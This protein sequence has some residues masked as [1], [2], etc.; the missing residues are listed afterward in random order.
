[1]TIKERILLTRQE[2]SIMKENLEERQCGWSNTDL[3]LMRKS[4]CR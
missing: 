1:V 4:E 3:L 2:Y